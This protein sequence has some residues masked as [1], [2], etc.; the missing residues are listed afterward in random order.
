M[1]EDEIVAAK[2]Y[3]AQLWSKIEKNKNQGNQEN[4]VDVGE[5][6]EEEEEEDEVSAMLRDRDRVRSQNNSLHQQTLP[7]NSTPTSGI[8]QESRIEKR[9]F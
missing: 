2:T 9:Q 1:E 7:H 6:M 8:L 5:E 3:I 4:S